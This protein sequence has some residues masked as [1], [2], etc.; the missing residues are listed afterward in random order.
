M[1]SVC[2]VKSMLYYSTANGRTGISHAGHSPVINFNW[3]M[4]F[5]NQLSS[6]KFFSP[7]KYVRLVPLHVANSSPPKAGSDPQLVELSTV[8]E[9]NSGAAFC[10]PCVHNAN[11]LTLWSGTYCIIY[12]AVVGSSNYREGSYHVRLCISKGKKGHSL[13]HALIFLHVIRLIE[14]CG[15]SDVLK[16]KLGICRNPYRM[17]E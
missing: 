1:K 17:G 13:M 7:Q 12:I 10:Q 3:Q 15:T 4:S 8:M 5:R 16:M 6:C 9:I 14:A 2:L 11:C